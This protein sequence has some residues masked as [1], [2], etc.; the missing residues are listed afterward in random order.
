MKIIRILLSGVFILFLM[1]Q[2]II[3][4]SGN[5]AAPQEEYITG[6][7]C[8]VGEDISLAGT[9]V[10]PWG[11]TLREGQALAY[12]TQPLSLPE[13]EGKN[14]WQKHLLTLEAIAGFQDGDMD[15]TLML[16]SLSGGE[17]TTPECTTT[18]PISGILAPGQIITGDT[19]YLLAELPGEMAA[20]TE[21]PA[22]LLS[23]I[24]QEG[25]FILEAQLPD[26]RWALSCREHLHEA[27]ALKKLTIRLS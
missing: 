4:G 22:Y 19:W 21:L 27:A 12:E 9:L 26:G 24:F 8:F 14:A 1:T 15:S 2:A 16:L 20:G 13:I 17:E 5:D 6:Q 7:V 25:T 10:L 23:G 11:E 3:P 18:A